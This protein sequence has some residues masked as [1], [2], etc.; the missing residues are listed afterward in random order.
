VAKTKLAGFT[1]VIDSVVKEV[2]RSAALVFGIVWRHCQME[3]ECCH[4]SLETLAGFID[5]ARHTVADHID[6]LIEAGY[7]TAEERVGQS[8]IYR[9]TGKM[10]ATISI[11]VTEPVQKTDGGSTKNV[12]PPVQKT[13]T[14]IL[15]KETKK[16]TIDLFSDL[17]DNEPEGD[18]KAYEQVYIEETKSPLLS[19]NPR[20]WFNGLQQIAALGATP[21]EFRQAIRIMIE[22]DYTFR[23]PASFVTTTRNLIAKRPK[24]TDVTFDEQTGALYV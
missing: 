2:G 13:D 1:P 7:L 5:M 15:L 18:Y 14:S 16:D 8:T 11:G 23:G 22:K 3:D 9:D 24:P 21:E 6:V 17:E 19:P 12:H 4:A 10:S 20:E